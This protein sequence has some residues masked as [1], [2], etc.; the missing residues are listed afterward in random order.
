MH[1]RSHAYIEISFAESMMARL[2]LNL[3]KSH[4]TIEVLQW[5]LFGIHEYF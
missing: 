5:F 4:N 2:V 1:F 3:L